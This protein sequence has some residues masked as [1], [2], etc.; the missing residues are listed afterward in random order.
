VGLD[1]EQADNGHHPVYESRINLGAMPGQ[2][3]RIG[4]VLID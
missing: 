4:S 3:Q 1:F 2:I